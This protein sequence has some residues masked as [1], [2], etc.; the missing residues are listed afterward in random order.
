[1]AQALSRIGTDAIF[2]CPA[3][4]VAQA[5]SK[6]APTF[7]YE[8]ND[9]N[10]PQLFVPPASFPYGAYHAAE[11]QYLFDIPDQQN[12]PPLTAS[13]EQLANAMVGYWTRFAQAGNPNGAGA[14]QWPQYTAAGDQFLSLQPPVP[15]VTDGFA[16]DHKC[17]FWDSRTG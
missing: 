12:A 7:A 4:R 8:F 9:P 5:V 13:Q 14:P 11:V 3:R 16:A 6:F 1:M 15:V 2:A 10:A 17:D